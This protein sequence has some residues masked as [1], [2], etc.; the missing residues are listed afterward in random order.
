[1]HS[2]EVSLL[3]KYG[4]KWKND[5]QNIFFS[6]FFS[7]TPPNDVFQQR[8]PAT[9]R[10]CLHQQT[11]AATPD[12]HCHLGARQIVRIYYFW[13]LEPKTDSSEIRAGLPLM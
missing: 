1:M 9:R 6:N 5:D 2:N 4:Q 3:V 10:E 8:P 13:G 7:R 11:T 12:Y